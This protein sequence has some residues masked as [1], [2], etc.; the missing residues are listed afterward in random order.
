M[1]FAVV[2]VV[3]VLGGLLIDSARN[4]RRYN[5]RVLRR[6]QRV[7]AAVALGAFVVAALFGAG[8]SLLAGIAFVGFCVWFVCARA[9]DYA[10]LA[11]RL[12]R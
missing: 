7:I 4:P 1:V 9:A 5:E 8:G 10:R 12:R 2:I 11:N 6:V 3:A